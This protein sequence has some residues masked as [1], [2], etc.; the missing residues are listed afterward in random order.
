MHRVSSSSALAPIN[1]FGVLCCAIYLL[2]PFLNPAS[3]A[4]MYL[5]VCLWASSSRIANSFRSADGVMPCA[6]QSGANAAK[7]ARRSTISFPVPVCHQ[8]VQHFAVTHADVQGEN[9]RGVVSLVWP[10]VCL[11]RAGV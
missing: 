7:R 1:V 9:R 2:P 8:I 10:M 6:T 5:R 4:L 11:L 3:H